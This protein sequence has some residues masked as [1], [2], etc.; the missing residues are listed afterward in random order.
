[1]SKKSKG[2][3]PSAKSK[4][5][6]PAALAGLSL[7]P[8]TPPRS[9]RRPPPHLS[10]R[11]CRLWR[12]LVPNRARSQERIALLTLALEA[13][14]RAD[15][16]RAIVAGEGLVV[17]SER[18]GLSR[19]HPALRIEAQARAEFIKVWRVLEFDWCGSEDS[20]KMG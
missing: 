18:S 12:K 2:G 16:A 6:V 1:M 13:L 3:E 8:P 7:D 9:S 15:Q 11:A 14:D 10:E 19:P 20:T 4:G 5:G 17:T